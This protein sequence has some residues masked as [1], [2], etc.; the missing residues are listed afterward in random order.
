MSGQNQRPYLTTNDSLRGF[1]RTVDSLEAC[2]EYRRGDLT[3]M[4]RGDVHRFRL[5]LADVEGLH[6]TRAYLGQEC[7]TTDWFDFSLATDK[8]CAITA[9]RTSSAAPVARIGRGVP[10]GARSHQPA[11][12]DDRPTARA[13]RTTPR[14]ATGGAPAARAR[15][16]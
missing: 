12:R 8:R 10:A 14:G 9:I 7:V 1:G 15:R 2:R 3:G 11:S 13:A 16:R 4:V 5:A 6:R